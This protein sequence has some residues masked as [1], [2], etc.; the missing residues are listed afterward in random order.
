MPSLPSPN[1]KTPFIPRLVTILGIAI[2]A[3]CLSHLDA[4]TSSSS[5]GS[6]SY[7]SGG[8]SSYGSGPGYTTYLQSA[9]AAN[10]QVNGYLNFQV[11]VSRAGHSFALKYKMSSTIPE[12]SGSTSVMG[13]A[14][15]ASTTGGTQSPIYLAVVAPPPVSPFNPVDFWLL[16][17]TANQTGPHQVLGLVNAEWRAVSGVTNRYYSIP[18]NRFGDSLIAGSSAAGWVGLTKGQVLGSYTTATVATI[19]QPLDSKHGLPS[20]RMAPTWRI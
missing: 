20:R 11:P 2:A 17:V 16:D 18:A 1:M 7:S 14:T 3:A 15:G 9:P 6:G 5:S 13:L 4:Q 8:S 10:L 19:K 12:S